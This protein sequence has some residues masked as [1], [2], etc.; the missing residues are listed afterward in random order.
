LC[1][2]GIPDGA[3]VI[4]SRYKNKT[5]GARDARFGPLKPRIW[6]PVHRILQAALAAIRTFRLFR[7]ACRLSDG[8]LLPALAFNLSVTET[9]APAAAGLNCLW[10]Q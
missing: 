3:A 10:I 1:G 8:L 7:S 2:H 4:S 6:G 5:L 9:N